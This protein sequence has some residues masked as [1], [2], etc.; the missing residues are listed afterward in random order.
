M[1]IIKMILMMIDGYAGDDDDGYDN[2][3]G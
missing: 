2:D 3:V 1:M